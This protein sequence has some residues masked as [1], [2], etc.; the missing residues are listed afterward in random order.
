MLFLGVAVIAVISYVGD[1]RFV[2]QQ[3]PDWTET[4]AVIED[5]WLTGEESIDQP[6][7]EDDTLF[8][9]RVEYEYIITFTASDG[10]VTYQHTAWNGGTTNSQWTIPPKGYEI[11][12]PGERFAI[13]YD[14]G[15]PEEY[16]FGTK[17]EIR[18]QLQ[19]TTGLIIGIVCGVIGIF[20]LA[21]SIR[22]VK[23]DRKKRKETAGA[24]EDIS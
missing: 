18:A 14:P 8:H 1:S 3:L 23:A 11:Y 21:L 13:V 7:G 16:M 10:D 15:S 24:K 6:T 20:I 2:I 5:A 17:A 12:T 22:G 19:D 4:T 9:Y